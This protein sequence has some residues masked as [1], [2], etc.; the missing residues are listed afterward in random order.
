MPRSAREVSGR[1][2]KK[3][4]AKKLFESFYGTKQSRQ[5]LQGAKVFGANFFKKAHAFL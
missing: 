2:F 4:D 1:L 5:G 3:S